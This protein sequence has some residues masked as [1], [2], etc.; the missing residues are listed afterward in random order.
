MSYVG[1][2]LIRCPR[3]SRPSRP[4]YWLMCSVSYYTEISIDRFFL[5]RYKGAEY[6]GSYRVPV[7]K[8]E[9]NNGVSHRLYD[10]QW[11]PPV[12]TG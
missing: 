7:R 6:K 2:Y 1:S 12:P 4:S 9:G 8:K 3:Q 5:D 10:G 11:R